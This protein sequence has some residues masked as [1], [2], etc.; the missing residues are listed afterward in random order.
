MRARVTVLIF[1]GG[2]GTE[3]T[4]VVRQWQPMVVVTVG[5][6]AAAVLNDNVMVVVAI[7]PSVNGSEGDDHYCR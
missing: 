1:G 6:F 4:A 5:V 2:S 7:S 3:P